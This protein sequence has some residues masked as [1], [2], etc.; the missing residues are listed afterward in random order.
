MA[1]RY[2]VYTRPRLNGDGVWGAWL[3]VVS[4]ILNVL[5]WK[6]YFAV[7]EWW[8]VAAL[9]ITG[10]TFFAGFVMLMIGRDYDSTIDQVD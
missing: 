1:V 6:W 5:S 7:P 10:A 9:V 2:K 8:A 4:P 3:V